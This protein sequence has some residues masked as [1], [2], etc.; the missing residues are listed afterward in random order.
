MFQIQMSVNLQNFL[1]LNWNP[2]IF[3]NNFKNSYAKKG[4][5]E[6]GK[7][8]GEVK[9]MLFPKFQKYLSKERWVKRGG[10][11]EKGIFF[12]KFQKYLCRE[13]GE[14]K[15]DEQKVEG[16]KR[17]FFDQVNKKL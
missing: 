10:G 13:E 4:W 6:G 12:P 3:L 8:E 17:M 16:V 2:S 15:K 5:G 1:T 11:G 9:K 14:V 7:R